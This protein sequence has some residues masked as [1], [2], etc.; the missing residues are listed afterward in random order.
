M[1]DDEHLAFLHICSPGTVTNLLENPAVEINVVDPI[2]RKGYRFKGT[3]EVL[4]SGEAYDQGWQLVLDWFQQAVVLGRCTRTSSRRLDTLTEAQ[5]EARWRPPPGGY[6]EPAE[7]IRRT[8]PPP[9]TSSW[10]R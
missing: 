5:I 2:V 9:Q 1:W 8:P 3:G 4:T 10:C 7:A 6:A